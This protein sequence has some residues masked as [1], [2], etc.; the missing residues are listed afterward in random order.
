MKPA[1][2]SKPAQK[3]VSSG[4]ENNPSNQYELEKQ[5]VKI[6]RQPSTDN[7]NRKDASLSNSAGDS[8]LQDQIN[9]MSLMLKKL[10]ARIDLIDK[11][12][13]V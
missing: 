8:D 1:I 3:K 4:A 13:H 7:F 12:S 9:S 6:R 10:Q 2:N 5:K 11:S